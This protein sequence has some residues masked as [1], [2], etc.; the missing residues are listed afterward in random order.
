V[1]FILFPYV[2][3]VVLIILMTI[4]GTKGNN[5]YGPSLDRH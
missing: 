2:G 4:P 3:F 5:R 1:A